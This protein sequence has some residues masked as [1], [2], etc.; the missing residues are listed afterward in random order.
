M[1]MQELVAAI[2]EDFFLDTK[3]KIISDMIENGLIEASAIENKWLGYPPATRE[4]ILEKEMQLGT[5]L[6]PSY[7]EFLECSNGFRYVSF[8]LNNLNSIKDIQWAKDVEESCFFDLLI[9]TIG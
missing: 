9:C 2:N 1:R 4:A 5:K 3:P 7:V 8:F 6:P